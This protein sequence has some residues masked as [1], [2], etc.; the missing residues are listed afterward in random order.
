MEKLAGDSCW[1]STLLKYQFFPMEFSLIFFSG[2]VRGGVCVLKFPSTESDTRGRII[3]M[4]S[5]ESILK[6]KY[7]EEPIEIKYNILHF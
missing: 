2:R 1:S 5:K 4:F 7:P 6:K 3:R